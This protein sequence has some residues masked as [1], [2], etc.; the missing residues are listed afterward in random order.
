[1]PISGWRSR[2]TCSRAC[3]RTCKLLVMS[4]T[5]DGARVAKLLGDAPVIESEGRAFPVETRYLGRD[6][7]RADRAA[8]GRCGGARAA[9]RAGLAAGVPARRRPKSAAPKRCSRSASAIPRSTSWRSTARSMRR[10]RI[11]PSRPRRP[12]GARSCWRPRSPRPRSPSRACASSSTAGWRGCRATSPMSG[13]TR[14]ETVRVSRAAADQRRGRAGRTEP[15]VCYRLW[16]EPQTASLEAYAR[17]EILSADLSGMLLDLAQ[18]GAAD[19]GQL[20]FLD[21]PPTGALAEARALLDRTRR[22]SMPTAASPT[23]AGSFARLPLPPRLARMVVDA[24]ARRRGPARR[25][26][27]RDPVRARAWRQRRRSGAPARSVPP[28][29]LAPRRGCAADGEALGGR[30][31]ARRR[32]ERSDL[33]GGRDPVAGLSRPHRQEPRRR[34]ARSCWPTAA[35]P[36]SIR[37]R[38]WRASRSSPWPSLPAPPRRAA[39]CLRRRSRWTRSS[40]V[41]RTGSN[42][43]RT[44][45]FDA[46]SASLRGRRSER[47]GAITLAERPM[48]VEP[49]EETARMLA[50]GIAA[51]GIDRLPWTKAL[52][53]WRDRVMFLRASRRRRMAG[54]V[55]CRARRNRRRLAGAGARWQDRAGGHLGRRTCDTAHRRAAAV[56][57]AAAGLTP[58]RRRISRRRPARRCR[59]TTTPRRVRSSRSACR[60]CSVSTA[61]RASPAAR[62]RWWS[63]FCRR[64]TGRCR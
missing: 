32:D 5:L 59:S 39:S 33:V 63:S 52:Q 41:S 27:R 56:E 2:A 49:D 54:P 42:A 58:R 8:G 1:M 48:P 47:L 26:H 15:G 6:A 23:R 38:R 64:R 11:A 21:P 13:L 57:Y 50:E 30:S 20:A 53:Q 37:R 16:D 61:I 43:A 28:R 7:A 14:L 51:L 35:A 3:A 40:S 9:R 45:R 17:P 60:S 29:S 24:A 46:A 62:C 19:P 31:P 4:A 12:A 36:M 44:S 55:R 10:R 34:M 25:R 18:W 22:A